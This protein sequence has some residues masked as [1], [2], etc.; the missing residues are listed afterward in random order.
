MKNINIIALTVL[1][2]AFSK[3]YSQVEFDGGYLHTKD[4]KYIEL[5]EVQCYNIK[6][7]KV[8]DGFEGHFKSLGG[9]GE[10]YIVA[11]QMHNMITIKQSHFKG[12]LVKGRYNFD[13]FTLHPLLKK[14]IRRGYSIIKNNGPATEYSPYFTPGD[15]I[16]VRTKSLGNNSYYW[17]PRHILPRGEYVAWIGKSFWVFEIE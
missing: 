16:D 11:S 10:Y 13:Y 17:E 7:N 1:L 15:E 9:R 5:P 14:S 4:E 12:I 6:I 3:S 8:S 2:L